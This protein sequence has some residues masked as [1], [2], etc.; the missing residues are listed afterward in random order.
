MEE[1]KRWSDGVVGFGSGSDPAELI[2]RM[3][4]DFAGLAGLG[5]MAPSGPHHAPTVSAELEF[6]GLNRR[7]RRELR[8]KLRG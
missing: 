6:P 8:R 3:Q 7:Q 1:T 2:E 4:R 5:V